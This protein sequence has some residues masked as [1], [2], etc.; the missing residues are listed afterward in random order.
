MEQNSESRIRPLQ[1]CPVDFHITYTNNSVEN[2]NLS[3]N[4]TGTVGF[5]FWGKKKKR[6]R[7]YVTTMLK[8]G[9]ILNM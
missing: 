2:D 7:T 6:I 1:I 4:G 5:P 3:K 8:M 9:H